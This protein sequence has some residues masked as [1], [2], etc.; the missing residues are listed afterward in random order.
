[1]NSLERADA[2]QRMMIF[3]KWERI[4]RMVEIVPVPGVKSAVPQ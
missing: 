4:Q 3:G 2:Q 1:M